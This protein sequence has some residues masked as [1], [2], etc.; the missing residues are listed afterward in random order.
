MKYIIVGNGV[1]AELVYKYIRSTLSI[2]VEGFM[3]NE[4]FINERE[5]MGLPVFR[6]EDCEKHY[7]S[8]EY[9]L[10]MG[11]GYKRMGNIRKKVFF[12]CKEK[13]Y[14]FQ[15]YIHPSTIIPK[16]YNIGEG[17]IILENVIIELSSTIGDANLFYG[18]SMVGHDSRVGDFNTF[19]GCSM[20]AGQVSIGNNCFLGVNSCVG[21]NISLGDYSLVGAAAYAYKDV[22]KHAVVRPARSIIDT[23]TNSVDLL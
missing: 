18:G 12:E 5:F 13:G 22:P 19:A 11:I 15:N 7:S 6:I 1:H 16:N 9:R 3:V 10:F 8:N 23:E 21:D 17:N 2:D 4:G 14:L 20:C